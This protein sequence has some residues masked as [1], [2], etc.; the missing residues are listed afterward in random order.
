MRKENFTKRK[1]FIFAECAKFVGY[2]TEDELFRIYDIMI[3]CAQSPEPSQE[4]RA[5]D[6]SSRT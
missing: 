6:A 3:D 4:R 2:L 5:A 1:A